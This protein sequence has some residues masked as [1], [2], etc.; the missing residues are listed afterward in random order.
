MLARRTRTD[1]EGLSAFDR[2]N[3]PDA[4]PVAVA[5]SGGGDSLALL[6]LAAEWASRARRPLVV[7][8]LDHGLQRDS[9][10]WAALA[11]ARAGRLGLAHRTLRWEG[12][13][14]SSGLP[15]AARAARHALL[16]GAARAAG[17]R[18]ILLGH[19][20]D[21]VLEAQAMRRQGS[22]VPSPRP[23]GPSPAW[24]QG[25]GVFLLRPLLG[26]RRADLRAWLSARGETWIDDPANDDLSFARAR[27]RR[28]GAER[29]ER[30]EIAPEPDR[31]A[32]FF[33][34]R[35]AEEPGGDLVAPR[36]AFA[37]API[38]EL[39]A[40]RWLA[41]LVL[42]AAGTVRPPRGLALDRLLGRLRE[43]GSFVA[44]LAGARIEAGAEQV[45]FCREPGEL[46]R[47][48]GWTPAA[49]DAVET[50]FDGRFVLSTTLEGA[51]VRPL[52]GLKGRLAPEARARLAA[53]AP[54]VRAGLPAIVTADGAVRC[55]IVQ[56]D[57]QLS[58]VPLAGERFSAALGAFTD[59]ASL[60]RVAKPPRGA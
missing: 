10:R 40:R 3:G 60:W 59:E 2:L 57:M 55:P 49:L 37:D 33:L 8:T 5:V 29:E 20:A 41:A 24:P 36:G 44:S 34:S 50:V 38:G 27:A 35:V 21:D 56:Q 45:R 31:A 30:E 51:Q 26:R 47:G 16:A 46:R 39:G 15:A 9:A 6:L 12:E 1:D 32:P 14:P 4:A 48:G 58:A 18:V 22:S 13:K 53:M 23:W 52:A 28:A 54:A 7:L 25:R 11:A 43:Q 19:T 17:A 42:C